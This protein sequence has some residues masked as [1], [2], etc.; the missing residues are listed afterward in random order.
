MTAKEYLN[1]YRR[2]VERIREMELSIQRLE[3]KLDVQAIR[4]DKEPIKGEA[5]EDRMAE[6]VS[7][8]C[9]IKIRRNVMK[10][11]A[12][13]LCVEIEDVIDRVKNPD[14]SRVLYD[15]YILGRGFDTIAEEM[16]TSSRQ[17]FR[18]HGEALAAAEKVIKKQKV[19]S[20]CQ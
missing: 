17:I 9:D 6:V 14:Y 5:P 3:D 2:E 13:L 8:I 1:Q 18:W 16:H 7:K 19:G 20:K 12:L 10:T 4:Y 15:R 11:Q